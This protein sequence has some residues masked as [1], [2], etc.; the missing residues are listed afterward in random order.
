MEVGGRSGSE[1]SVSGEIGREVESSSAV[2]RGD[3]KEKGVDGP[4]ASG[5]SS[6]LFEVDADDAALVL[7]LV[8]V[9][10]A[11]AGVGMRLIGG[12]LTLLPR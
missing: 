7:A 11:S 2:G 9:E 5:I 3:T 8:R 1:M 6:W 4:E 12:R 10:T